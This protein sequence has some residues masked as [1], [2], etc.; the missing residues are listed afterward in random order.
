MRVRAFVFS[1]FL[2]AIPA[3]P[4]FA[5]LRAS[6]PRMGAVVQTTQLDGKQITFGVL[7]TSEKEITA[8]SLAVVLTRPNGET[9][10]FGLG[11]DF[12]GGIIDSAMLGY[13]VEPGASHGIALGDV[14][15]LTFPVP[16]QNATYS[17]SVDVV[18]YADATAD[19][20]NKVAFQSIVRQRKGTLLGYQKANQLMAAALAN[21][22]D[23]HPSLTVANQLKALVDANQKKGGNFIGIGLLDAAQNLRNTP[24]DTAGRSAQEDDHI[25]E[26][27]TAYE[28]R[29]SLLS[30]HTAL[31]QEVQP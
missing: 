28:G 7:N 29:I 13:E 21:A 4:A 6:P 30:P 3:G 15:D 10:T 9:A 11:T 25:R 19:V 5:Q 23:P 24:R 27:I 16:E 12:I 31:T 20:L 18:V 26:L 14:K 22:D 8:V 2:I 17:A 1:L